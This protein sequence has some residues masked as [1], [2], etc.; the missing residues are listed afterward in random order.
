M[1]WWVELIEGGIGKLTDSARDALAANDSKALVADTIT[2]LEKPDFTSRVESL[3]TPVLIMGSGIN[4]ELRQFAGKMPDATV[5]VLDG[6]N[7][8]QEVSRSDLTLPHI[9]AFLARVEADAD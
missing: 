5:V 1:G 6:L 8:A 7:H 3:S 9:R 2:Y 4:D